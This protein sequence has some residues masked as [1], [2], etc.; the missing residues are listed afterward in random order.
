[1]ESQN[2]KVVGDRSDQ[3]KR[4]VK[5]AGMKEWQEQLSKSLREEGE[6]AKEEKNE[7]GES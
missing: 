3:F 2:S 7:G 6:K 5:P 4:E 1:M